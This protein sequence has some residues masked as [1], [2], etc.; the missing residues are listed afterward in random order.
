MSETGR[1]HISEEELDEHAS[2]TASNVVKLPVLE[3][4]KNN[5]KSPTCVIVVGMAGSGKTTFMAQLY[6]TLG[7]PE[8][9]KTSEGEGGDKKASTVAT[10]SGGENEGTKDANSQS[11]RIGYFLNLDPATKAMP[12]GASIDIRDTVDYKVR[13]VHYLLATTF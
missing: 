6:R 11:K 4:L 13:T 2:S 12:F 1:F 10:S 5:K 7:L 8:P 9:Q 3:K